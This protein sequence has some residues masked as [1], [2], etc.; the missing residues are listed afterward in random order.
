[1][2]TSLRGQHSLE[3]VVEGINAE[4]KGVISLG[5]FKAGSNFPA[6]GAEFKG[7]RIKV[8][9]EQM[10]YAFTDL[11]KGKYAVSLFHDEN[12]N[13]RLDQNLLG[14][15]KEGYGFSNNIVPRMGPPSFEA[16]TIQL[17]QRK[18]TIFISVRY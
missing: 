13:L 9:G 16:T 14:L 17:D 1:M 2:A 11:P 12:E 8:E 15:P 10:T 18:R 6:V 4:K 7:V 3:V 5:I